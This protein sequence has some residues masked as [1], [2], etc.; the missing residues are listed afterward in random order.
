MSAFGPMAGV[1]RKMAPRERRMTALAAALVVGA[2]TLSLLEWSTAELGRLARALPAAE[3]RLAQMQEQAEELAGLGRAATIPATPLAVRAEAAQAAAAVRSL[4]I[5]VDTLADGLAV[6]GS[7]PAPA[8]LEWLASMQAEQGLRPVEL[9]LR[10]AG[11]AIEL[12]ARL[13]AIDAD[14]GR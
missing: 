13:A 6:S 2:G 3:A 12:S 1:M 11:D 8:W 14:G 9:E 7:G 5:E 10:R 4:E